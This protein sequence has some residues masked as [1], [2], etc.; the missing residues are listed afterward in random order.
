M[1]PGN[2]PLR[3]VR[4]LDQMRERVRYMHYI[5]STE[6]VYVYWVRSFIPWS[7]KGG[8]IRYGVM[9]ASTA[10]VSLLISVR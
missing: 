4:V 1:K 10:R 5:L 3:S 8:R 6:Q 2:P 7:G 9:P